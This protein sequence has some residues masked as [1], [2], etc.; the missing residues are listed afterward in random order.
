MAP[1]AARATPTA[2]PAAGLRLGA[3][4]GH[5]VLGA[6]GMAVFCRPRLLRAGA[7]S[8][9]CLLIRSND[10]TSRDSIPSTGRDT[11]WDENRQSAPDEIVGS[12]QTPLRPDG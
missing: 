5:L 11:P 2:T 12:R 9:A 7:G 4:I 8:F 6:D 1:S 3:I 10:P